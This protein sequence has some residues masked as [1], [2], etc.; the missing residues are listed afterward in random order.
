ML[1]VAAVVVTI[2]IDQIR[3]M[4]FVAAVEALVEVKAVMVGMEE[5]TCT[6]V[7]LVALAV[8]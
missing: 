8:L 5:T 4:T 6:L 3:V 7:L 2:K 1:V